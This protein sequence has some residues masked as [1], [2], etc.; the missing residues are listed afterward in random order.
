MIDVQ[1]SVDVQRPIETVFEFVSDLGNAPKWQRGVVESKRLTAGPVRIG[2]QFQETVR[3]MGMRFD[4]QCEVVDLQP[5]RTLA[6]TAD[7]KIVAYRG[8]F[9]FEPLPDNRGTRLSVAGQMSM[10]GLWRVLELIAGGEI[11]K[12]SAAELQDIKKAIEAA[13]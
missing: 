8:T 4:A 5:P 10:K 2:T 7:G 9:T 11:R 6:M 1:A 3:M 12:E 13:S